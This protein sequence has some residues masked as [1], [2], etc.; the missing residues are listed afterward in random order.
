MRERERE[1]ERERERERERGRGE[2]ERERE[3]ERER[4]RGSTECNINLNKGEWMKLQVQS[5]HVKTSSQTAGLTAD[6][7]LSVHRLTTRTKLTVNVQ[8]ICIQTKS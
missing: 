7:S 5:N 4:E 8:Y 1:K 3:G 6:A 2:R